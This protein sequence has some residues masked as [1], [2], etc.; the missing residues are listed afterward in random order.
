M[1]GYRRSPA[2]GL[3]ALLVLFGLSTGCTAVT[4]PLADGVPVRLLS[5]ELLGPAKTNYQTIHFRFCVNRSPTLTG[6]M[7]GTC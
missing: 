2:C 3:A 4:N 6:L 5:P 1:S 7:R